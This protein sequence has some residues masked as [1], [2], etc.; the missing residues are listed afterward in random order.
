[1]GDGPGGGAGSRHRVRRVPRPRST[2]KAERPGI[3]IAPPNQTLPAGRLKLSS[4]ERRELIAFLQSL[5][6]TSRARP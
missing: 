2:D 6:D 4:T 3:G 1:M 5:T